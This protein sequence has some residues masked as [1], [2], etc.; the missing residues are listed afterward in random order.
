MHDLEKM[1]NVAIERDKDYIMILS[2]WEQSLGDKTAVTHM[3]SSGLG[4]ILVI[5][6]IWALS[7]FNPITHNRICD[8]PQI[9]FSKHPGLHLMLYTA[10]MYFSTFYSTGYYLG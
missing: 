6:Q 4:N 1:N 10:L 9:L 7:R 2:P 8:L 5:L 3:R